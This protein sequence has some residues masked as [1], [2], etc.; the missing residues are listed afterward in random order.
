MSMAFSLALP[1]F[2][3]FG[4]QPISPV[5]GKEC[6]GMCPCKTRWESAHRVN[7]QS[8][9]FVDA[10]L[11]LS[12]SPHFKPTSMP[13]TAVC[14]M[15][16]HLRRPHL[17]IAAI[18]RSRPK[19]SAFSAPS[20]CAGEGMVPA[21]MIPVTILVLEFGFICVRQP[22]YSEESERIHQQDELY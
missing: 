14:A 16:H 3:R 15:I 20:S 8:Y 1:A 4:A 2:Q 5:G 13:C 18:Q 17:S 9:H 6:I 21:S 19:L 7:Y 11:L 10:H 22:V 12:K